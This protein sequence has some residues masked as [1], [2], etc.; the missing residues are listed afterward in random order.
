MLRFSPK[1]LETARLGAD[2]SREDLAF[3]S[4]QFTAKKVSARSIRGYEKGE[5]VPGSDVLAALAKAT[6]RDIEFFYANGSEQEAALSGDTFRER[7]GSS[8]GASRS[9]AAAK[10]ADEAGGLAA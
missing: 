4:R 3:E 9:R 10:D 6:G 2:M 1:Q 5:Y 7:D 8:A